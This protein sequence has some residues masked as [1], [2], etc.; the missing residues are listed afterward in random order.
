MTFLNATI[1]NL[2]ETK[3]YHQEQ[4]DLLQEQ[5]DQT[6]LSMAYGDDAVSSVEQAIENINPE[7]LELLKEH[8]LSL[9]EDD[10]EY[11]DDSNP[12]SSSYEVEDAD[13]KSIEQLQ[14]EVLRTCEEQ[15]DPR[16]GLVKITNDIYF[17]SNTNHC[18]IGFSNAGRA[19]TYGP[20]LKEIYELY[21][22]KY[23]VGKP[24]VV[25]C[26][27][28]LVIEHISYENAQK[29][30]PLNLKKD[31]NSKFNKLITDSWTTEEVLSEDVNIYIPKEATVKKSKHPTPLVQIEAG[32]TVHRNIGDSIYTVIGMSRLDNKLVAECELIESTTMKDKIGNI[33]FLDSVYLVE[34]EPVT[35]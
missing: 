11:M 2:E 28:E 21:N 10:I 1:N 19:K 32:D 22:S 15:E 4:I 30:A 26:K 8:L 18:Y 9:F 23:T 25:D 3:I 33:Y 5:I 16:E 20:H 27:H 31:L 29:L 6:K 12:A 35:V 13:Y 7:H 17:N 14:H 34:E 24:K